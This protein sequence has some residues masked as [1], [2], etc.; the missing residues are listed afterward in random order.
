MIEK[1]RPDRVILSSRWLGIDQEEK[2]IATIRKI[3]DAGVRE[4]IIFG[5]VPRWHPNLPEA[6]TAKF[7]QQAFTTFP[8]RLSEGLDADKRV[9]D[10]RL[11]ALASKTGGRYLSPLN[12]L[13]NEAGC[14]VRPAGDDF[15]DA[16][17]AIDDSHLSPEGSRYLM[18]LIRNANLL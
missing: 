17:M 7:R 8:E 13:C 3:K 10:S 4:V 15:G 1:V 2:I 16:V 6:L 9:I 11:A 14:L 12:L 18:R 5:P